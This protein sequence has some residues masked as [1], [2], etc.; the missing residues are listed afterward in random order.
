M[1][2]EVEAKVDE[3]YPNVGYKAV[4]DAIVAKVEVAS[5]ILRYVDEAVVVPRYAVR[6]SESVEVE[7]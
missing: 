4:D 5:A 3:A 1:I 2:Q 7:T 6:V